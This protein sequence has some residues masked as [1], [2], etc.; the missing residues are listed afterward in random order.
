MQAERI[1]QILVDW[2]KAQPTIQAVAIVGSHARGAARADSDIDLV[3]LA[4]NPRAFRTDVA[5]L[6]AID[7]N[8]IGFRPMKWQDEDY[9]ELWSRRLWLEQNG[10]EIEFGFASPSWADVN[11]LDPGTR[12]VI[13]DGCCILHDPKKI[14]S[15]L[16][17]AVSGPGQT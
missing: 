9:G 2:A 10:G 17:A 13:A 4:T 8:A 6:D 7:W 16:C 11:P 1:L 12:R 15:R 3:L 14:L 5:W